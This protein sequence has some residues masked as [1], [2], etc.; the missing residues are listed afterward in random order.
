MCE[1]L[2]GLIYETIT[3]RSVWAEVIGRVSVDINASSFWMF[4]IK[5]RGP[6]FLAVQGISKSLLDPYAAYFHTR[7]VLMEEE[8]RRSHD[9]V[10]RALRESDIIGEAAW[11]ASE[12]YTDLALPNGMHRVLSMNLS[13]DST[14]CVPFLTFFRPRGAPVFEDAIVASCERLIPHMRRAIRLADRLETQL[15]PIPEWTAQLL[16]QLRHGVFLLDDRMQIMHANS[17]GLAIAKREDG[18][19]VQYHRL[20]CSDSSANSRLDRLLAR[21]YCFPFQGGE[22]LVPKSDGNWLMSVAPLSGT[23]ARRIGEARCRAIV[24]V[25]D[26]TSE[27]YNLPSRLQCLYHLTSAEARVATAL[28][29]GQPPADIADEHLVSINTIRSQIQSIY[30]KLDVKRQSD[31][32]RLL[33]DLA[34][35][36]SRGR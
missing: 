22:L 2:T 5:D 21:C 34:A 16:E 1:D 29:G 12:I 30:S 26:P 4:R 14:A 28:M 33:R 13:S 20:I 18:I 19:S 3:D 15:P 7:D 23:C 17:F 11:Q 24:W 6:D 8:L 10:G 31:L 9:F 32:A 35:L 36:P 25:H 27:S